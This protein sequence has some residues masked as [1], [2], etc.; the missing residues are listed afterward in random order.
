M[1]KNFY[2]IL[3]VNQEADPAK[4]KR[5]YRRAAKRYHPDISPKDEERFKEVQSAYETLS[6]PKKKAVYDEQ[7][8]TRPVHEAGLYSPPDL[9]RSSVRFFDEI[10]TLF[11]GLDDLWNNE[12]NHLLGIYGEDRGDLYLEV[13]LTQEEATL[14]CEIPIQIPFYRECG[15]CHGTGKARGLI[16]GFCRGEG[17]EKLKKEMEIKIPSGVRSGMVMRHR[18]NL[19]GKRTDLFIALK[20]QSY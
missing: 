16:C 13:I 8:S 17:K 10:R 19:D 14:G 20:V 6:D 12:F 4:I 2:K 9:T 5:A 11:P 1:K 15:R 7:S 18:I 3:G